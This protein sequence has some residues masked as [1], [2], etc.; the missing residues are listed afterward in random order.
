MST[1]FFYSGKELQGTDRLSTIGE[2]KT[3]IIMTDD[4]VKIWANTKGHVKNILSEYA[5]KFLQ[6]NGYSALLWNWSRSGFYCDR[7][8]ISPK[9]QTYHITKAIALLK[10]YSGNFSLTIDEMIELASFVESLASKTANT[11]TFGMDTD[12]YKFLL[13]WDSKYDS[14]TTGTR[15]SDSNV[16][17]NTRN[18]LIELLQKTFYK[19]GTN[20]EK[21]QISS[22]YRTSAMQADTMARLLP[23]NGMKNLYTGVSEPYIEL[24]QGLYVNGQKPIVTTPY[25]TRFDDIC[26]EITSDEI[27]Y[28]DNIPL[29]ET[30]LF[31]IFD[32]KI[33]TP[34]FHQI[35]QAFDLSPKTTTVVAAK[36]LFSGSTMERSRYIHFTLR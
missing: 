28:K 12:S 33:C 20:Y 23:E 15:F 34:S 3:I 5:N 17:T 9:I 1:R 16:L 29:C 7:A 36:G 6:S 32:E 31:K 8:K 14:I 21:V 26:K 27:Q 25:N 35:G 4:G 19:L 30:L 22:G 11:F 2:N 13:D 10:K 18:K 24:V